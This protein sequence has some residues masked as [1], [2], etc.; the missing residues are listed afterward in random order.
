MRQDGEDGE[1]E[2]SR[3]HSPDLDLGDESGEV[4]VN[5]AMNEMMG[6]QGANP[7]SL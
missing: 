4:D 6:L 1:V 7:Q 3:A 5:N 2:I